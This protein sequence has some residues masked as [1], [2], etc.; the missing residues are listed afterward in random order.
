MAHL[1]PDNDAMEYFIQENYEEYYSIAVTLDGSPCPEQILSQQ[2]IFYESG[3]DEKLN[4]YFNSNI[5]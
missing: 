4:D 3:S 2:I 1:W 5:V